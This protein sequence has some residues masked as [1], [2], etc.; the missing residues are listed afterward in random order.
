MR[1]EPSDLSTRS[2]VR[3]AA[4]AVFGREGLH[5]PLRSVAAE[6]GLTA[7]RIVQLFGSKDAL[8]RHCDE[9]VFSVIRTTKRDA[10][11]NG[12]GSASALGR[13]AMLD[14]Y[15]PYVAY[16]ARSVQAGG[17]HA[18]EFIDHMVDDALAYIT[19]AVV[20]GTVVPSRDERAR[21]RYLTESSLGHLAL[22]LS[23]DSP[24]SA[25]E[26]SSCLRRHLDGVMLPALELYTQG[27]LT[28]RRM[29]DSYLLYVGDPPDPEQ[30][31]SA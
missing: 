23:L 3:E 13:L 31:A 22:R 10:M 29:L 5:A 26:L 19:D 25:E 21:V 9:H 18:R 14:E 15:V 17:Q 16:V 7:G 4:I 2:R 1:L 20:A 24:Q 12:A 11:V 28:D 6:A 8:Q 30:A 27:F